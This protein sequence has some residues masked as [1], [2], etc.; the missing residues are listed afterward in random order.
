LLW[1]GHE[2]RRKY[3]DENLKVTVPNTNYDISEIIR[4]CMIFQC[5]GNMVT[6]DARCTGKNKSGIVMAKETFNKK[7]TLFTCKIEGR[8]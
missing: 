2:C 6:N 5:L 4:E 1:N 8:N 3:D 7:K